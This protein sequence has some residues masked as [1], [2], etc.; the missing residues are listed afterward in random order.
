MNW[1]YLASK[2]NATIPDTIGTAAE[3][4]RKFFSQE[5]S[6]PVEN[7]IFGKCVKL[8]QENK[9]YSPPKTNIGS[10]PNYCQLYSSWVTFIYRVYYGL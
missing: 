3:V 2:I 5:P 1:T 10:V 4:P 7:W 6:K 8:E 9:I